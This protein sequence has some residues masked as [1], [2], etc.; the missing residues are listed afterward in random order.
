MGA[1]IQA[2]IQN[3]KHESLAVRAGDTV[4]WTQ[5]DS[6]TSHTTTSG[7]PLSPDFIWDSGSLSTGQTFIF[8]FNQ[9]GTFAYYCRI[10]PSMKATITVIAAESSSGQSSPP[11]ATPTS[12]GS[13]GD[14][15]DG[16]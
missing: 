8:S 4:V 11:K 10:H 3:F 14:G 9:L 16:Y 2:N 15:S 12:T 1:T 5:R 13:G 7:I 6:N